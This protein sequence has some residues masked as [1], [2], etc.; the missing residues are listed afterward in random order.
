MASFNN[1]HIMNWLPFRAAFRLPILDLFRE[2]PDRL[3][4][5]LY[6]GAVSLT[7]AVVGCITVQ[8]RDA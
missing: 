2:S 5:G 7:L 3:V 4:S 6:F 8:R 1:E